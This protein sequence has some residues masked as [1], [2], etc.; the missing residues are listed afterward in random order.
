VFEEKKKE[1]DLW[2]EGGGRRL[3]EDLIHYI[4]NQTTES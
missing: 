4:L 3:G 1:I 2:K